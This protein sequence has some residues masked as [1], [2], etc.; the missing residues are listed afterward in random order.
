MTD[1]PPEN[2]VTIQQTIPSYLY[3]QYADDDDLQAFVAAYNALTQQYV[4]W[5][6]QIG[7]PIYTGD[8]ISGLL[9]DWVAEGLYGIARPTLP[10]GQS[11][12]LGPFNTY[13]LNTVAFNARRQIGTNNYF[14]TTDDTFKRVITWLFFKGDGKVFNIRWLKRRIV[15]FLNGVNG[16]DADT[17]N[18]YQI[19]VT[20]GVNG[21][22]NIR[23]LNGVR[24]V[25][26]G[27]IFNTFALNQMGFNA[28]NSTFQQFSPVAESAILKAAIEAGVLELPFQFSAVVTT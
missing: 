26:G 4:D 19:S 25:T 3:W 9:L 28:V 6:N 17:S 11:Q 24:T 21:Q 13:A 22:I 20:F 12:S 10:S 16:V 8:Q 27:A 5:F 2:P 15:R 7:L 14:A 18:T 1:F 23:V